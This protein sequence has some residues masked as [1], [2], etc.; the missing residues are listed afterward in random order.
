MI[1]DYV[2]HGYDGGNQGGGGWTNYNAGND[3]GDGRYFVDEMAPNNPNDRYSD[4]TKVNEGTS[5]SYVEMGDWEYEPR[6]RYSSYSSHG[7]YYDYN[8][9]P[10]VHHHHHHYGN[11][12]AYQEYINH[13]HRNQDSAEGLGFVLCL[14]LFVCVGGIGCYVVSEMNR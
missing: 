5:G 7:S 3:P 8:R 12:K 2:D 14:V 4:H 11:G 6:H 1:Y 10:E 13:S 9:G